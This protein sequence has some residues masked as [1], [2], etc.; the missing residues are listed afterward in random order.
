M[1]QDMAR[2]FAGT[3]LEPVAASLDRG[4]DAQ[5]ERVLFLENLK[6]LA[7]LGFMGLNVKAEYGGSDAGVVAFSLAITEIA[8]A[9]ASTEGQMGQAAYSASKGG[10][11]G[12]TLPIAR[13][14]AIY[15]IRVNTIAPG[16]VHTPLVD[17][18][19]E[20]TVAALSADVPF[21]RRLGKPDEIA[22]LAQSIVENEYLNGETIRCDGAIRMQPR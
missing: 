14:L 21:P 16:L 3:V 10:I 17:S 9:C 13:D 2:K 18:L 4:D 11:V 15:G 19:P 12:M 7:G 5:A 1:I 6:Q 8:R 20:E 22:Q